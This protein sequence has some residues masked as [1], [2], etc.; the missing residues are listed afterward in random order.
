MLRLIFILA[1][2]LLDVWVNGNDYSMPNGSPNLSGT[3]EDSGNKLWRSTQVGNTF[4]WVQDKTLRVAEGIM[5]ASCVDQNVTDWKVFVTFNDNVKASLELFF[6][7]DLSI[8]RSKNDYFKR[9][10]LLLTKVKY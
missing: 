7:L 9:V 6:D 8:L 4:T 5:I 10:K 2:S 1:V 3:W